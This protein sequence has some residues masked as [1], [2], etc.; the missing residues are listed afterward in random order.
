[1]PSWASDSKFPFFNGEPLYDVSWFLY[2][3]PNLPRIQHSLALQQEYADCF[4][5]ARPL[6]GVPTERWEV[7]A[8]QFPGDG[9]TVWTLY[10]ARYTTVRGPVLAVDHQPG[11]TYHD[12]WN[13]EPLQPT[14]REGKAVLELEL[15]PQGLGCVVQRL[16]GR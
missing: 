4:S 7:H 6:M 1:M 15:P 13:D 8:N 11:A 2:S 5:S 3:G 12:A 9:R 16:R 10:N 14:I